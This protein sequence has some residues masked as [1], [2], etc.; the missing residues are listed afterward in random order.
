MLAISAR[1]GGS[2]SQSGSLPPALAQQK[3]P[4]DPAGR[5]TPLVYV[6]DD[7]NNL[8][9]VFDRD[10]TLEYTITN[11]VHAPVGMYVDARHNLWVANPGDNNV[12]VFPRGSMTP[13]TT[14]E[15]ADQLNDVAVCHDGTVFVASSN[16]A[17]GVAVYPRGHTTPTR[18]LKP[19]RAVR[20]ATTS[21]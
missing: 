14:L 8:I 16:N 5:L 4:S 18:R 2:Q 19:N 20:A 9:D 6:S 7:A 21:R 3:R 1:C 17:G 10:G 11:G 13:S 15:D 12:L